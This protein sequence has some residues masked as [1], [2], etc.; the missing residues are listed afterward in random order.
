MPVL[1]AFGLV[2]LQRIV[3][4]LMADLDLLINQ[5][6]EKESSVNRDVGKRKKSTQSK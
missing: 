5:F 1:F 4:S 2:L 3:R 6:I